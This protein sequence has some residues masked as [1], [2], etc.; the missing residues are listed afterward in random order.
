MKLMGIGKLH[1]LATSGNRNVAGAA[2]ALH[3]ELVAAA[4]QDGHE[5]AEA[6]PTAA[7]APHRLAI[8][9]PNDHLVLITVNYKAQVVLIEFA[10]RREDDSIRTTKGRKKA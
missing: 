2:A 10:G 1:A 8:S 7:L 3:A 6:Y 5:A 9:L 4:W